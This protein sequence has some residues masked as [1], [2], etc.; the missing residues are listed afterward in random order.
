MVKACEWDPA[1]GAERVNDFIL[2]SRGTT[3]GYAV[4]SE[5]GDV[6]INTGTPEQGARYRERYEQMLGRPLQ[7]SK[8]V[9]TQNHSDLIGGWRCFADPGSDTIVQR[10]FPFLVQERT[11]LSG[12][13]RPRIWSVMHGMVPSGKRPAQSSFLAPPLPENLVMFADSHVFEAGGRRYEL[14]SAPSGE[15]LDSIMVWMPAEKVVFTGNWMGALYGAL[16]HFYTPR[17][18]RARSVPGFIR[19]LERMIAWEPELLLT[20]HD[21]PIVGAERIRKDM[22]KLLEAV[23]YIHD[24]TIKGMNARK[25]IWTLMSEIQLPER[26]EMAPGRGPARWYVRAVYEEYVGWFHE[27]STTELYSVPPRSIWQKLAG[28]AGGPEA[29]AAQAQAHLAAGEPVQALHYVE[30]ALAADPS[31]PAAR[32]A[33]IAAL[34]Q[35]IDQTGGRTFDE[36]GWLETKLSE[37]QAALTQPAEISAAR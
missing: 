3:N 7:V 1:R 16:P 20:G 31:N 21:E 32:R 4:T 26:L 17:G 15:T 6:V 30:I 14:Y 22:S 10:N 8:I 12:F 19:E 13:F 28:M 23:R 2:L 35:L 25:D 18:D 5:T 37:A 11:M 29:L 24:E 9:L 36:L 27:D 33:E 34:E